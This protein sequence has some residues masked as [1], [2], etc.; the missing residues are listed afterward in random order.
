MTSV[1]L[2]LAELIITQC[3]CQCF[4]R[5]CLTLNACMCGE[6][7][8]VVGMFVCSSICQLKIT[9][10]CNHWKSHLTFHFVM[11]LFSRENKFAPG[12]FVL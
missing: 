5:S 4:L 6:N 10:L 2:W 7:V 3:W 8:V 11:A 9:S 12:M 1:N